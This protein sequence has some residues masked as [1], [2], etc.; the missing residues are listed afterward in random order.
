[1]PRRRLREI[2]S[3]PILPHDEEQDGADIHA[4]DALFELELAARLQSRGIHLISFDDIEFELLATQVNVQCKRLHSS[5]RLQQNLDKACSQIAARIEGTKKR[6]IVAIG[7]D[8]I[9]DAHK[10][11]WTV[12]DES[13][14]ISA[15]RGFMDQFLA[16]N[17]QRF[18]N[19]L[20]IRIIAILI[21]LRFIA[22][23]LDRNNLLTRG[24]ETALFPLCSA[25]TLQ[26]VD[27]DLIWE[28]G[29]KITDS[30]GPLHVHGRG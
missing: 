13:S 18:I 12:K 7:I 5:S 30:A 20:D 17:K 16:H 15:S 27:T 26:F 19:I 14:L 6:G 3:G 1:L 25:A 29:K 9:L 22:Q 21:D 23:V 28:L 4:R 11:I 10:N 8:K 2:L 24:Y